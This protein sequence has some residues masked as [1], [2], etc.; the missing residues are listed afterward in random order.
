[1]ARIEF[2]EETRKRVEAIGA[3]DFVLGIAGAIPPEELGANAAAWIQALSPSPLKAVVVYAGL[4]ET[5]PPQP[6]AEGIEFVPYPA[7]SYDPSLGPWAD[8]SGAQRTA[9]ALAS[10]FEARAC[11][12]LHRDL[13][14]LHDPA[15]HLLV[16]P[17]LDGKC[18]LVTP[19]YPESKYE[20][21]INKGLLAPLSR[22]LFGRR[23]RSP[24]PYDFCASARMLPKLADPG[25]PR[26]QPGPQLLWPSNVVAM[27]GG[28]LCQSYLNATHTTHTD[29]LELSA[30]LGQ[31]AG[32]LFQEVELCAPHWQRARASQAVEVLGSPVLADP[33]AESEA[34]KPLDTHPLIDSFNLASRNLEEVWRLV[35]PPVTLFELKQLTRLAL[36]DFR[37]PDELWARIVYDFA[38]A[39]RLRRIGRTHLLGALTPLYLGWVASYAQEV[40]GATSA[41]ADQRVEQ[42]AHI[43]EAN[44]PYFVARWRWPDRLN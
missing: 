27:E 17:V 35:L 3:A 42:L 9:M 29:G 40:A 7:P 6:S 13:A 5:T 8:I 33:N 11:A 19:I 39:Y 23:V 41:E 28:Q 43:F 12:V 37:M 16:S 24:L 26:S 14:A 20:G 44:K 36:S 25:L 2:P 4:Q 18:D 21:L 38:L 10:L 31:L 30:V 1:M 32:A 15:S 22:A 34:A